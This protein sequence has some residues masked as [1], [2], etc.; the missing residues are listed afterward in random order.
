[1]SATIGNLEDIANFLKAEVYT[2]DFRPVELKEYVKCMDNIWLVDLKEE[3]ILTDLKK[4]NY[5]VSPTQGIVSRCDTRF[6]ILMNFNH[7]IRT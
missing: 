4:I 3:E 2:K 1:M 6:L 7:S 5:A